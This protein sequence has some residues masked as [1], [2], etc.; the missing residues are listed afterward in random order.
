MWGKGSLV[1][2]KDY[3][4][5]PKKKTKNVYYSAPFLVLADYGLAGEDTIGP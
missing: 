1:Y 3:R 5:L 2:A 4:I